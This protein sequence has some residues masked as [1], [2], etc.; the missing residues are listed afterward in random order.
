[1][2]FIEEK[3]LNDYPKPVF[4][5]ELGEILSQ[6][7]QNVC[8][9]CKNDGIK[10]TGFFCKIPLSQNNKYIPVFITNNHVIDQD[11]INNQKEIIIKLNDFK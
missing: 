10:G 6:M 3:E 4:I 7:K 8:K 11:Y 1:M 5:D 9:I 2:D